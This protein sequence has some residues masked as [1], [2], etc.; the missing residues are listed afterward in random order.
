MSGT[1]GKKSIEYYWSLLGFLP[2]EAQKAAILSIDG[3]LYLPAGPGSGKTRVLLWRVFNLIVFHEVDPA[4]IFLTTFTQKAARQL[5]DGLTS[6]LAYASS[7]L[8]RSFEINEMYIGTIHSLCQKLLQDRRLSS[9]RARAR[10]PAILDELSQFFYL[11]QGE[12]YRRLLE[13]EIPATE[14]PVVLWRRINA[15]FGQRRDSKYEAI[16]NL[17][18]F[19]NRL[20]EEAPVLDDW[21]RIHKRLGAEALHVDFLWLLGLY[22]R[23]VAIL[24]GPPRRCDLSLLQ[25]E[26]LRHLELSDRAGQVFSHVIV[27]EYQ[28]TNAVQERLLF[29]LAEGS[30]NICVVG[31]DDQALYRFRGAR[32]ENFT[33]FPERVLQRLGREARV[34]PLSTNYRSERDIVAAYSRFMELGAWTVAESGLSYRVEK[35]IVANRGGT[36]PRVFRGAHGSGQEVAAEIAAKVEELI[37]AGVVDDPSQIA[38]LFPSLKTELVRSF[39]RELEGRGLRVYA[40]R[41]RGFLETE[42]AKGVFG[43]LA[44]ILG[45]YKPRFGGRD[46]EAFKEWLA[47]ATAEGARIIAS[48]PLALAFVEQKKAE[49]KTSKSDYAALMEVVEAHR[50][51]LD[52]RAEVGMVRILLEDRRLSPSCRRTLGGKGMADLLARKAAEGSP[53]PLRYLVSSATALD[54]TLLDL[55]YRLCGLREFKERIEGANPFR[56]GDEGPLHSLALVG[57]SINGYAEEFK[58]MITAFDLAEKRLV[59]SFFGSYLLTLWRRMETEFE[60]EERLFPRGRIPFLTIHQS[61]GLEFPVVVLGSL[62]KNERVPAMDRIVSNFTSDKEPIELQPRFDAMRRFYV[63]MSRAEEVLIIADGSRQVSAEFK[64]FVA[65]LPSLDSLAVEE[66]PARALRDQGLPKSYSFT[67]DFNFYRQCPMQYQ[68]FKKFAFPPSRSQTMAFGALVHDTLEDLHEH[69]IAR[70]QAAEARH[71]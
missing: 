2:N 57:R 14:E 51:S 60:D 61:K 27:D 15:F 71:E 65:A 5:R 22:E 4:R 40:P 32:V 62:R 66:L 35:D 31:D 13:G 7:E 43:L 47:R 29:R 59:N 25:G 18:A 52:D 50:W 42:E 3:P 11:Y 17:V 67:G 46:I 33:R 26:A 28:D 6:L 30:G 16:K 12:G 37:A 19:F 68:I 41:A 20:S 56:G 44:C 54:W 63:A 49:L 8:N 53:F 21:R 45:D 9:S 69:L 39:Q 36:G 34:I 24:A 10:S 38:F 64:G 70:R 58:A 48:D 23:Y 1:D 55:F